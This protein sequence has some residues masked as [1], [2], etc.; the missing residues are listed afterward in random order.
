M[1]H[2]RRRRF[3]RILLV[4]PI[5]LLAC[6]GIIVG[7]FAFWT[8]HRLQ[9]SSLQQTLFEGITYLREVR[10]RPRP[11]VI[12][13]VK[14]DL[15]TPGLSF[16]VSPGEPTNGHEVRAHYTTEFLSQYRLQLAINGDF[17]YPWW[18]HSIFDWYPHW[19]DPTDVNGLAA[20]RGAV[21]SPNADDRPTLY[22]AQDNVA[23][24]N[25]PT[26]D[27]YNAI[28]GLPLIVENGQVTNKIMPGEYYDGLHP[29]TAVALDRAR[30]TLLLFVV[31]GR[32]PHY[33]EG[34]QLQ[35]L[36]AIGIEYGADIMLNLDGG[37]SSSL[38]IEDQNGHPQILN[39][40]IDA[41]IP[42]RE[43]PVGNQLGVYAQRL[44]PN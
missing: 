39:S 44:T 17:F 8:E 25:P 10:Q 4:S 7:G 22:L 26:G 13:I 5:V 35:E 23:S 43:R 16:L 42:G 29:R 2:S 41:H 27:I 31:D 18:Y 20:S 30:Q 40:P 11:L 32:Q 15:K 6:I 34:V 21:Y 9:P 12:H 1:T 19:N 37:G 36:A 14:I 3:T 33:S 38:V 28:S 24:F